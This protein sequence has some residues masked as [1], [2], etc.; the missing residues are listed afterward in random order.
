MQF[1]FFAIW[2]SRRDFMAKEGKGISTEQV[3]LAYRR[4]EGCPGEPG[5]RA[6]DDCIVLYGLE[7]LAVTGKEPGDPPDDE[8]PG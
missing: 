8:S 2:R 7:Y 1:S 5:T 6:E 4:A 3:I